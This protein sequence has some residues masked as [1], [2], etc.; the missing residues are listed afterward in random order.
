MPCIV[1]IIIKIL[2]YPVRKYVRKFTYGIII[3]IIIIIQVYVNR[4][5][6]ILSRGCG[7]AAQ[8]WS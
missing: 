3:I 8:S 7:L 5:E 1:V 6:L 4:P 2:D